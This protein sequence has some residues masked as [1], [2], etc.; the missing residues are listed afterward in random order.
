MPTVDG[1]S[2]PVPPAPARA[3]PPALARGRPENA[4]PDADPGD[5]ELGQARRGRR[6]ARPER[7]DGHAGPRDEG[8]ERRLVAE[9][10]RVDAV[11]AGVGVTPGTVQRGVQARGRLA[12]S[13][14]VD[15]D[16]GV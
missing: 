4:P 8:R 15:V 5:A 6:V 16:A 13:A 12:G 3:E 10:D 7:V 1:E 2:G 11:R 9:R 14:D